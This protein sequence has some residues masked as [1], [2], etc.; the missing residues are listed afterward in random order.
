[1]IEIPAS[2]AD[3]AKLVSGERFRQKY[4]DICNLDLDGV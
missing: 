2:A 1:M 4:Q 3:F